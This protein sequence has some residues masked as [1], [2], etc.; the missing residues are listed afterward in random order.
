MAV[1]DRRRKYFIDKRMQGMYAL[2][3]LLIAGT[4]CLF[5]GLEIFRS[6][7]AEFGWPLA[8]KPFTASDLF[9]IVKLVILALMGSSFFWLMS[10]FAGHKIAGPIFRLEQCLKEV[11]KGNYALRVQFR[12]KDFFQEIA[13]VFNHMNETLEQKANAQNTLLAQ[14]KEK[15]QS[16]PQDNQTS[17]EIKRLLGV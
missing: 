14:L 10:S 13:E 8:G 16:L 2:V 3:N 17:Q 11:T 1:Q 6:F 4:I 5:V 15:A 12:K 9:F 7:Y